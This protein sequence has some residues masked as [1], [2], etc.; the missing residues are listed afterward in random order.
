MLNKKL[1]IVICVTAGRQD[2]VSGE[3]RDV[4]DEAAASYKILK[5]NAPPEIATISRKVKLQNYA[6]IA[7][8]GGDG[9]I[10]AALKEF[11]IK[12]KP[13]LILPGGTANVLANYYG[14][15]DSVNECLQLYL[16]NTYITEYVDMS[17]I[18]GEPL[19][20]DIHMGL[21]T[22]A[23]KTTSRR[24]KKRIGAPAYA[25]TALKKAGNASLQTYQFAINDKP[26]R[27]V[28]GY[29]FIVA[30]QG[31]HR[32]L[33]LPLFPHNHAPGLVQLAI[34][35]SIKASK[36]LAWFIGR[37]FGKN[38]G[39]II[40]VHRAKKLVITKAPKSVLSDDD[41][42]SINTPITII[43][44]ELSAKI[45]IPPT[46]TDTTKIKKNLRRLSLWLHLLMQRIRSVVFGRPNLRY[47]HVAPGLYLGGRYSARS[48]KLF[49]SWGITGIVSMRRGASPPAPSDIELLHLPTPDWHPPALE[50]LRSG[51]EFVNKHISQGGSVYVHCKLGEGRGPT[52]AS[53][54]LISKGLSVDESISVLTK[55]RPV[56]RP[57]ASQRKRLAEWQEEYNKSAAN[58]S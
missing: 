18:N 51:V 44:G 54:Y 5:I 33:G 31:N 38:I 8:Y 32:I 10:I 25:W 58:N 41:S 29:T 14:L 19:V 39:S 36:L 24:L 26:P 56:V 27:T 48:Y 22:T 2:T 3:I 11:G 42:R 52:M 45:I 47:S 37:L 57:N 17:T 12:G 1:L 43:G 50:S 21:W 13:V 9:T 4:M 53:A 49:K 30:N 28:R 7:V 16:S 46:K 6:A 15:P 40:E 55:Y 20:L 35:K 34:V 23:I